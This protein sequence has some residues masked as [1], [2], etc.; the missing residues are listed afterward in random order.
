MFK[1][2]YLVALLI[3]SNDQLTVF[4]NFA[5][6][7]FI[8]WFHRF[9]FHITWLHNHHYCDDDD[10]QQQQQ[11]IEQ[12]RHLQLNAQCNDDDDD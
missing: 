5:P 9:W 4:A 11:Q 12:R 6:R 7:S 8:G 10:G 2:K 1:K 3:A